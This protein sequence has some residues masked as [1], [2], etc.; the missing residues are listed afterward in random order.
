MSSNKQSKQTQ[1][2][3]GHPCSQR[4]HSS[5]VVCARLAQRRFRFSRTHISGFWSWIP[6]TPKETRGAEAGN[7]RHPFLRLHYLPLYATN[8]AFMRV[9]APRAGFIRTA[10][11]QNIPVPAT[12]G[13][14]CKLL[15][16]E[17]TYRS[18]AGVQLRQVGVNGCKEA[19]LEGGLKL[20]GEP[21]RS[22]QTVIRCI[23]CC[24]WGA[25]NSINQ[26]S[27]S[28]GTF[29][30]PRM[31]VQGLWPFS[32][33]FLWEHHKSAAVVKHW[34]NSVK[35]CQ[36]WARWYFTGQTQGWRLCWEPTCSGHY[37]N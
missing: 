33:S 10:V 28:G 21:V 15:T 19:V 27:S 18:P 8:R 20:L 14:L 1:C 7:F 32:I 22:Q 35:F 5:P 30:T 29:W 36:D 9:G 31:K 24:T 12:N 2:R 26:N 3:W 16:R 13:R 34:G 23:F 17:A 11:H 37:F 25:H 4:A 6:L